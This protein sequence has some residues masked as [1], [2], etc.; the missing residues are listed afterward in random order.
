M[1]WVELIITAVVSIIGSS[2]IWGY[3]QFTK[4]NASAERTL[5]LGI[6][7]HVICS[8][9]KYHIDRKK[10]TPNEY[11]DLYNRLFVPYK[12]LGGNGSAERLMS[13]VEKLPIEH[14]N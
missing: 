10:I 9:A 12:Q 11:R 3:I 7:Y 8:Q 4:T 14:F 13:E 2:G 6:A 5:L 1:G